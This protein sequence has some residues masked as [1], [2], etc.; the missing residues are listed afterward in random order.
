MGLLIA[1]VARALCAALAVAASDGPDAPSKSPVP[2]PLETPVECVVSG[3][4]STLRSIEVANVGHT[5]PKTYAEGH[6]VDVEGFEWF[7]SRHYALQ[8]DYSA[9][10]AKHLLSLLELA[11]PHYVELF[12]RE[13]PDSDTT[14]MAVVYG[15]SKESLDKALKANGI[16]WDFG[17]GGITYERLNIAYQ[18][19]SGT[20]QYHQRYILLHECAHL[21]QVCLEGTTFTTPSWY[22]EGV[23]DALAHHVW[24]AA[25]S[26]LTVDVVDKPTVNDWYHDGLETFAREPF[27]ASDILAGRRGGRDL[28]F[29]L[30]T[31]LA[32]DLERAQRFAIWRDELFR[33]DLYA[34]CQDDSLRLVD[35]LFGVQTLDRDFDAWL[36]ARRSSFRYVDWG[37]EQDGDSLMSY[38]WPQTGA[39]SQTDLL[40]EPGAKP[41]HDRYVMDYP[42]HARSRL[43]DEP[44]RGVDEPIVG[45]LVGFRENPD[46]GEVGLAL[47]VEGRSFASA[48][49]D[50]RQTLILDASDLGGERRELALS[51]AFRAATQPDYEIGLT[52]CI[53]RERLELVARA[54]DPSAPVVA[55]LSV[56]LDPQQRER[57]L[58]RPLA[59]IS[60]GGKHWITPYV[61]DARAPEPELDVAAPPNRW[62]FASQRELAAVTRAVWRLGAH[63]PLELEA[64]RQALARS[65]RGD[66]AAQA[67]ARAA[68]LATLAQLRDDVRACAAPESLR[69][70]A[71]AELGGD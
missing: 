34:K 57:S 1:F 15:A 21:Y 71:L 29:L 68:Y 70:A 55:E 65:A 64:A 67:A 39:F 53:R 22:F 58:R 31:Y 52:L 62:R 54:G 23:A 7:V 37:W 13:L 33:L 43:V 66:A 51:D 11:H 32:S 18:Y 9:E 28:G 48:R 42:L 46:A 30:V 56:P 5:I 20:L 36:K 63:A 50:R 59:V 19:P 38:G 2:A 14:R 8:T 24:E 3:R 27:T 40:F 25:P 49:V 6:L 17:G 35:E 26:R 47:G 45:C 60:R 4:T 61:D 16:A 10:R 69:E 12:G 44:R 41:A